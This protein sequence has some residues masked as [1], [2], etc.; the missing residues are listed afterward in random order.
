MHRA[1]LLLF[2]CHMLQALVRSRIVPA[3]RVRSISTGAALVARP[4]PLPANA[5]QSDT[6]SGTGASSPPVLEGEGLLASQSGGRAEHRPER[7]RQRGDQAQGRSAV[8]RAGPAQ[9]HAAQADASA[10]EDSDAGGPAR[11]APGALAAGASQLHRRDAGS[12]APRASR[13]EHSGAD[14]GDASGGAAARLRSPRELRSRQHWDSAGRR[15]RTSQQPQ[16]AAAAGQPLSTP[17]QECEDG[18]G[19][20][21]AQSA[22]SAVQPGAG[23][24]Q[25]NRADAASLQGVSPSVQP[26]YSRKY[27]LQ[28]IAAE[29]K[30]C[31][32]KWQ[33]G[34]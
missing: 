27:K 3:L 31:H 26:N 20:D 33:A 14:A 13:W 22:E 30:V 5:S 17:P 8:R 28:M 4:D 10:G 29:L 32:A 34:S 6:Q 11:Q 12:E 24:P 25:P 16:T 18:L 2:A 21:A 23:Y 1:Q 9:A 19:F 15:P 7:G